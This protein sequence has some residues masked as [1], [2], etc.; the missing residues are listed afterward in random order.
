MSSYLGK[1]ERCSINISG[2]ISD[3]AHF[4]FSLPPLLTQNAILWA[5]WCIVHCINYQQSVL[6]TV[7]PSPHSL[8]G[9]KTP[10]FVTTNCHLFLFEIYINRTE[11]DLTIKAMVCSN[12]NNS[13]T[14]PLFWRLN[15][16]QISWVISV[17]VDQGNYANLSKDTKNESKFGI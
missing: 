15:Q 5:S 3:A 1:D 9:Q 14:K 13:P 17:N 7:G 4:L 10:Q 16:K 12:M 2:D 6:W 8:T 11:E